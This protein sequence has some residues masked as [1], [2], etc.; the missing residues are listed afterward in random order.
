MQGE[1]SYER[2]LEVDFMW[3]SK[4]Q[5]SIHEI[6]LFKCRKIGCK[7]WVLHKKVPN[8]RYGKEG[9]DQQNYQQQQKQQQHQAK[10]NYAY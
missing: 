2:Q 8:V 10:K 7:G 3:L 6:I 9:S 4:I 5:I 1:S